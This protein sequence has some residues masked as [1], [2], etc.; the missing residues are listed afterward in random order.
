MPV[1]VCIET[2]CLDTVMN[3]TM[4]SGRVSEQGCLCLHHRPLPAE[5]SSKALDARADV[6]CVPLVRVETFLPAPSGS[7]TLC[8]VP[9]LCHLYPKL[10]EVSVQVV[11]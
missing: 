8:D 5:R 7:L 11:S 10:A 9:E 3:A 4:T 1:Y 6:G 2:V